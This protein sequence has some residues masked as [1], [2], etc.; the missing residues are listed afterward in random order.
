MQ[1]PDFVASASCRPRRNRV[2]CGSRSP[3]ISPIRSSI[4]L[5]RTFRSC[6][7]R[8]IF[9]LPHGAVRADGGDVAP[10]AATIRSRRSHHV[11]PGPRGAR[12]R[13]GAARHRIGHAHLLAA[14]QDNWSC[15]WPA[16]ALRRALRATVV[17][18]I[19]HDDLMSTQLTIEATR[20]NEWPAGKCARS[21]QSLPRRPC[22]YPDCPP[23]TALSLTY[24]CDAERIEPPSSPRVVDRSGRSKY[25]SPS[26]TRPY[27]NESD[28]DR[29]NDHQEG[30]TAMSEA[31]AE[32]VL[33]ST[34]IEVR[35]EG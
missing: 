29:G 2:H 3:S 22:R 13:P 21:N 6:R 17:I 12:R 11:L 34:Y 30:S 32:M 24:R 5:A 27:H 8:R 26:S 18:D 16:S 7:N 19:A 35:A 4:S 31:I 23:P 10:F 14:A 33:P 25:R 9:Q 1:C 28:R 15:C 20:A